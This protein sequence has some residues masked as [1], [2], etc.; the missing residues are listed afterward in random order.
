MKNNKLTVGFISL[1]I[2]IIFFVLSYLISYFWNGLINN[3]KWRIW[4]AAVF[5]MVFWIPIP[6]IV[7]F[8]L[9]IK[10]PKSNTGQLAS[11]KFMNDYTFKKE[12]QYISPTDVYKSN[13]IIKTILNKKK[14]MSFYQVKKPGHSLVIGSTGSGKTALLLDPN[15]QLFAKSKDKPSLVISDPKGELFRKHSQ[16]LKDK[17]YEVI[18]V[19]LRDSKKSKLW[20]PLETIWN[21]WFDID[22][23]KKISSGEE[24][25]EKAS[26]ALSEL[27]NEIFPKEKNSDAFF[28]PAAES[29]FQFF[30]LLYLEESMDKE[31]MTIN[32]FNVTNI[33]ANIHSTSSEDLENKVATLPHGSIALSVG[34]KTVAKATKTTESI[35]QTV[36]TKLKIYTDATVKRVTAST[37]FEIRNDVPQ[38]IFIIVP[39]ESTAKYPLVS[40]FVSETYKKLVS[41]AIKEESNSLARRVYFLL[42]EFGNFP[43]ISQM[44]SMITVSRSRNIFFMLMLQS[45][46]Q[47]NGKYGPNDANTI[48]SNCDYEMFL[49]TADVDTA[50]K[51]SQKLGQRSI[52]SRSRS[53]SKNKGGESSSRSESERTRNLIHPDELM[54]LQMGNYILSMSRSNP[55]KSRLAKAWEWK[56][57]IF[58]E[59]EVKENDFGGYKEKHLFDFLKVETKEKPNNEEDFNMNEFLKEGE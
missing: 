25:Q 43:K 14:Q 19:N 8:Y 52:T 46:S 54:K 12:F 29:A 41:L 6:L 53:S 42:D 39:D 45:Y 33:L 56:D 2:L 37:N 26:N 51:F 27:T 38:A 34:G 22:P 11:A 50:K 13:W 48:I 16:L 30:V 36:V 32:G 23:I 28:D 55:I 7:W 15:I 4:Q 47:L 57:K 31:E 24:A 3:T 1:M 44:T 18:P 49:L 9:R 17:G 35:L 40:L 10:S 58:Q 20:N 21:L 59:M 5:P